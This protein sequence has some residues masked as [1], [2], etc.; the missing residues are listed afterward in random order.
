MADELDLLREANPVPVTDARFRDRPLHHDAERRLN[1]LLHGRRRLRMRRLLWGAAT[2]TAVGAVAFALTLAGPSTAPAVAAPRPLLPRAGS[3]PVPLDRVAERAA[4]AARQDGGSSRLVKGTHVQSWS[5]A[6]SDSP[7]ASPPITVPEERITR[8]KSDDSHTELVVATDP[9]HPGRP[10]I[11]DTDTE[12]SPRTVHDGKVLSR[13]SYP[14]S[15]SDAPPQAAPPHDPAKL[16]AYLGELDP[17]GDGTTGELLDTVSELLNHWTLGDRESAALARV[18]ADA[19]DLRPLGAVTDRLGRPGQAYV[20][21]PPHG[22]ARRMVI[23]DPSSGAVLGL[24]MTFTEDDP[25]FG[26]RA[27]DVMQYSAWMR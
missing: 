8:W 20:W 15:W 11:A 26:V 4:A 27:G 6:M 23:L 14:P 12:G 25:E 3:T 21:A 1:R 17:A 19:K 9:L 5:L 24:E 18:L 2:A 7:R 10:V 13:R 22:E 16:R